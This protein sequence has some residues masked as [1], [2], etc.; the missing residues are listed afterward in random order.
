MTTQLLAGRGTETLDALLTEIRAC[1]ICAPEIEPKPLLRASATSRIAIVSQA[2][3]IRAHDTGLSFND[4]SGDRLRAWMGIDRDTFYDQS[5]VAVV[6]MG[7]CFPGH[8]ASG[9]DA[10]PRRE[11]AQA[12][13]ARLFAALPDF[14]LTL[15]VGSYAIAGHLGPRAKANVHATVTAWREYTPRYLPLPHPSWRNNAWLNKNPWF[16]DELLPYLRRR[17]R[18]I[19]TK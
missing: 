2:P 12:W 16:E 14:P 11:C 8:D 17:V 19:L 1:R 5:R 7:F 9:G 3:G 10:P 18:T 4:P 15:L 13:R 6:S